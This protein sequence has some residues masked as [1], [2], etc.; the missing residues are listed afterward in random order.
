MVFGHGR[1]LAEEAPQA[2]RAAPAAPSGELGRLSGA[3]LLDRGD[4]A[5]VRGDFPAAVEAY[6]AAAGRSANDPVAALALGHGLFACGEYAEAAAELR[7]GIR[8]Y[9]GMVRVRMNR[10]DFYGEP[11]VFDRQVAALER[12]VAASPDDGAARFVL[13][14]NYFFTQQYGKARAALAPLTGRDGVA[15]TI[16]GEC[17]G[18]E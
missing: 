15:R 2:T 1:R 5:F 3:A 13:G 6:R 7:R 10:R 18:D 11:A 14:Y 16:V 17:G 12:H 9:P 8:L 4:D